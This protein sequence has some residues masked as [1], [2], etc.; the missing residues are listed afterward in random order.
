ME[1]F[2]KN[3]IHDL[4]PAEQSIISLNDILYHMT[5]LGKDKKLLILDPLDCQ[6]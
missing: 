4:S 2:M 1:E 5:N 6:H 3:I